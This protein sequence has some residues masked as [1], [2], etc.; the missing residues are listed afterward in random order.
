MCACVLAYHWHESKH[1]TN[2]QFRTIHFSL[3]PHCLVVW[4]ESVVW[5]MLRWSVFNVYFHLNQD[6]ILSDKALTMNRNA[7]KCWVTTTFKCLIHRFSS[8]FFLQILLL[9]F[10]IFCCFCFFLF[11][12]IL[13]YMLCRSGIKSSK[14]VTE[15]WAHGF[16]TK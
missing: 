8:F 10:A 5:F 6:S 16:K 13:Y 7:Q 12:C 14:Y 15:K 1:L 3:K 9:L 2:K 4:F 11:G